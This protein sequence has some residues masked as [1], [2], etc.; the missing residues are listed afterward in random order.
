MKSLIPMLFLLSISSPS[1]SQQTASIVFTDY[2]VEDDINGGHEVFL[3]DNQ[4]QVTA[5]IGCNVSFEEVDSVTQVKTWLQSSGLYITPGR[6]AV[7]AK[8]RKFYRFSA[9]FNC[10][11]FKKSTQDQLSAGGKVS[12]QLSGKNITAVSVE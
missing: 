9:D 10:D 11:Q 7:W 1:F 8:N 12:V 5:Q 2:L 6:H 3:L 4:K